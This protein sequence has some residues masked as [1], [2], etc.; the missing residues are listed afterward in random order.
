MYILEEMD[1]MLLKG[2]YA[3]NCFKKFVYR[4]DAFIL[5]DFNLNINLNVSLFNR[6][7]L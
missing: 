6:S 7:D 4:K 3:S 1:S 5:K 2:T